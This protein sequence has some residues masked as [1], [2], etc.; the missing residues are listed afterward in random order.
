MIRKL[1]RL[2]ELCETTAVAAIEFAV[3]LPVFLMATMGILDL[4][5][6]QYAGSV[7]QGVVEKAARDGTLEGYAA[8]QSALDNYIKQQILGVWPGSKVTIERESFSSFSDYRT[9][10]KPEKFIDGDGD[11][12]YKNG[13]CFEDANGNGRYDKNRGNG[14]SGNGGAGDIVLL[15]ATITRSRIFPGWQFIGQPQVADIEATMTL[16]NQPYA[17]ESGG[18]QMI[19]GDD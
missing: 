15:T 5:Y 3:A 6:E 2:R 13:E 4:A 1:R 19:C 12:K 16:R 9:R 18:P 17:A 11:G 10:N 7:L 8:D 14:K